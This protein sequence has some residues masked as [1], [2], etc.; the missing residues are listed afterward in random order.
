MNQKLVLCYPV[1]ERHL[2]LFAEQLPELD[3][4]NAGQEGIAEALPGADLFVGHAKVPVPWDEVVEGGRL[5]LIQSSAAGLD[6]CL[7]PSVIASD[8]PVCSASGLFANQVAEQTLALLL[9]VIRSMPV[10]FR[11]SLTKDFVRQPT[12]DLHGKRIGIVGLGG[13]GRRIAEVLSSFNVTIRATDYYPVSKPDCVEELWE[14]DQLEQ[15]ASVSDVLILALPLNASTRHLISDSVIRSMPKGSYLINVARGPVVDET[16]L[17]AA[18]QDQHLRAAGLDVTEVEPLPKHSPLWELPNV[19]ISP[20]VGAQSALRVDTSTRFACENLRRF[21]D[22]KP[23]LNQVDKTL[24]FPH[25]DVMAC[26]Q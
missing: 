15:L 16:S 23:L 25:P 7:V 18:L 6:H 22:G 12:D 10:F 20:H 26:N 1:E 24:G 8:I 4:I 19:M 2:Q 9:G 21:L 13:N 5:R 3:V 14:A 11:Q 17:I